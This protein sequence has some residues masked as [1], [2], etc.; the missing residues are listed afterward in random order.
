MLREKR[1]WLT[2]VLTLADTSQ[3]MRHEQAIITI[4]AI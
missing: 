2:L 4:I 1:L 3:R